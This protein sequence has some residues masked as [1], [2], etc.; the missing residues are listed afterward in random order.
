LD[1][2]DTE[3]VSRYRNSRKVDLNNY[4]EVFPE[5]FGLFY[6]WFAYLF[7]NPVDQVFQ[8]LDFWW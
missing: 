3:V 2:G 5:K 8:I 1:R 4:Y 6:G 7:G